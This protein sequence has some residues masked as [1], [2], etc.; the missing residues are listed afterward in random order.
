MGKDVCWTKD[1]NHMILILLL[2]LFKGLCRHI[3]KFS[4]HR[5]LGS[6]LVRPP[7]GGEGV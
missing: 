5:S 2:F 1:N 4:F 7:K 6:G 3:I